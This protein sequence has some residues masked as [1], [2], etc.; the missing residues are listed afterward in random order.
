MS[1]LKRRARIEQ[2]RP[3]HERFVCGNRTSVFVHRVKLASARK[4]Q[5]Y[6]RLAIWK[7]T[8][9]LRHEIFRSRTVICLLSASCIAR[10]HAMVRLRRRGR[11]N[12]T[13]GATQTFR[14]LHLM[15][16][17]WRSYGPIASHL[18]CT[19]ITLQMQRRTGALACAWRAVVLFRRW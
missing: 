12:E 16:D 4:V 11:T 15:S 17:W 3:S 6:Y 19:R 5:N 9:A 18:V 7:P 8:I 10:G 1:P 14:Q 13:F 2:K